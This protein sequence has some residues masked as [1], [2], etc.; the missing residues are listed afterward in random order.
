MYLNAL[1]IIVRIVPGFGYLPIIV[2]HDR[3]TGKTE[4]YYRGEMKATT[5][6][7]FSAAATYLQLRGLDVAVEDFMQR[8][9]ER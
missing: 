5:E 3:E 7:A 4:E 9:G 1:D 6:A 2:G 8:A